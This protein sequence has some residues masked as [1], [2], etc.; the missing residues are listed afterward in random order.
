MTLEEY[1]FSPKNSKERIVWQFTCDNQFVKQRWVAAL[2][3]L[4]D[5]YNKEKKDIEKFFNEHK[6]TNSEMKS[7][8][9]GG[10][11]SQV[12]WR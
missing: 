4:R 10:R 1:N 11:N 2:E 3:G 8:S 7:S 5:Y 9:S 6:D 12:P